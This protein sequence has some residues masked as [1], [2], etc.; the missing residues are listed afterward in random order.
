MI[1]MLCKKAI[2]TNKT[3]KLYTFSLLHLHCC[4][5]KPG[6]FSAPFFQLADHVQVRFDRHVHGGPPLPILGVGVGLLKRL[7]Q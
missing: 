6:A 2:K 3:Q 5:P 1:G 4:Q 7:E